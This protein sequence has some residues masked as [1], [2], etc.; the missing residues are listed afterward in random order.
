MKFRNK[1]KGVKYTAIVYIIEGHDLICTSL[2]VGG[3]I[4]V[5]LAPS[6]GVLTHSR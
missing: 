3:D 6:N 4:R 1:S 5:H 2:C